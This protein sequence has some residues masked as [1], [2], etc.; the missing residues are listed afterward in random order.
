M[1]KNQ[2]TKIKFQFNGWC[3]FN[4]LQQKTLLNCWCLPKIFFSIHKQMNLK[5]DHD[6]DLSKSGM[7]P[8]F[9]IFMYNNLLI[10]HCKRIII[11]EWEKLMVNNV[12]ILFIHLSFNNFFYFFFVC[13]W[14][15]NRQKFI[16]AINRFGSKAASYAYT[17]RWKTHRRD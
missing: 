2:W 4:W 5:S 13:E 3:W 8:F 1:N 11:S 9:N 7:S 15:K 10:E 14:E 12:G 6:V 16:I 17:R